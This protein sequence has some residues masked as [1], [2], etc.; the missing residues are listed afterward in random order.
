M[1]TPSASIGS[2]AIARPPKCCRRGAGLRDRT[3][4]LEMQPERIVEL[5]GQWCGESSEHGADLFDRHCPDLLGLS[6]G[7]HSD[8]GLVG[9]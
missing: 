1:A 2:V 9:R 6:L 5:L 7:V 4:Q 8:S 3:S